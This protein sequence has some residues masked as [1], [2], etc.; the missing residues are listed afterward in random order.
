MLEVE[1]CLSEHSYIKSVIWHAW[2]MSVSKI[3]LLA[4]GDH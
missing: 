4:C 3:E 2:Q 1:A